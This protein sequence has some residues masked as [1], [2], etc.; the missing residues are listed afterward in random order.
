MLYLYIKSLHIIFVVCWFA[1]LFYIVRLFVYYCEAN[2]MEQQQK[3]I[4]QNQYQIMVERLFNIITWPAAILTTVFGVT[5]LVLNPSLLT[6]PWMHIK[7]A[8]V[9]LLWIYHLGCQT[10][11]KQ[12]ASRTLTK[13]SSYFRIFNEGAT[14]ILFSIVFIVILKSSLDWI[15]GVLALFGLAILLMLG[16]RLYKAILANKQSK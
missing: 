15:F 14:L 16:I 7:L 11:V 10:F 5:M 8:F 12:I 9:I 3:V 2:N 13:K 6:I 1:G 4:L